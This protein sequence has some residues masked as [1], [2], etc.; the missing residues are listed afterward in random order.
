V[1]SDPSGQIVVDTSVRYINDPAA[2]TNQFN[3]TGSFIN[4]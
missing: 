3:D 4:A 2:G 1:T